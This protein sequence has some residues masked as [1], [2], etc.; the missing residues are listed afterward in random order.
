MV[1]P[2][3]NSADVARTTSQVT[4]DLDTARLATTGVDRLDRRPAGRLSP[5]VSSGGAESPRPSSPRW[6]RSWECW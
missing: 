5:R 6:L 3:T 4:S 1:R 2:N